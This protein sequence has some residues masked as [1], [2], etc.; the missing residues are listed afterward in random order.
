M[1]GNTSPCGGCW[2]DAYTEERAMLIE[3]TSCDAG[4]RVDLW[5]DSCDTSFQATQVPPEPGAVWNAATARGWSSRLVAGS[6]RHYCPPCDQTPAAARA[7]AVTPAVPG[8]L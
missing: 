8:R 2:E 4:V 7:E 3:T 6:V 1:L 5:C